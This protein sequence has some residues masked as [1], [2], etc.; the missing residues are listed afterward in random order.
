LARDGRT[1][2]TE[3]IVLA[4]LLVTGVLFVGVT[5]KRLAEGEVKS[6]REV[7]AAF[8]ARRQPG[9]ELLFVGGNQFSASFYGRGRYRPLPDYP[10]LAARL[11]APA[12]ASAR[13]Y[14]AV[15][16][17]SDEQPPPAMRERMQRV[18]LHQGYELLV[19]VR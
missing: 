19:V 4:G 17:W 5:V 10:A 6:A 16:R 2:R 1:H 9:D 3:R 15:R 13:R 11:D 12:P 18:G 14:V 8:E 7:I